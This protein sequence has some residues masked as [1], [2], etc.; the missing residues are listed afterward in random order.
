VFDITAKHLGQPV[1]V[2]MQTKGDW[3]WQNIGATISGFDEIKRTVFVTVP[4]GGGLVTVS[5]NLI[6]L[7]LS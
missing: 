7:I 3:L 6:D 4:K 2:K 1:L 5:L